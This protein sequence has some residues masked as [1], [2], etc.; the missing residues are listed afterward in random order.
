MKC[1]AL[2]NG[3]ESSRNTDGFVPCHTSVLMFGW[4]EI[5]SSKGWKKVECFKLTW[6]G[7]CSSNVPW[8]ANSEQESGNSILQGHKSCMC[9]S[10]YVLQVCMLAI[11]C[12][13][14]A[15]MRNCFFCFLWLLI[16]SGLAIQIKVTW[17]VFVM[18]WLRKVSVRLWTALLALSIL[19][20]LLNHFIVSQLRK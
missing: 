13:L 8:W 7:S 11:M 2:C 3:T 1:R 16:A 19:L 4:H 18:N 15:L 9:S 10:I 14:C 5:W 20:V 17:D 12:F 6:L